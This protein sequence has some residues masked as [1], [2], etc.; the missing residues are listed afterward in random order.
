MGT[1]DRLAIILFP[2]KKCLREE[3][4][5]SGRSKERTSK[6]RNLS[7]VIVQTLDEKEKEF[8][9]GKGLYYL[10]LVISKKTRYN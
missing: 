1:G 5:F 8:L 4:L 6:K 9:S 2:I 3:R 10:F 7:I